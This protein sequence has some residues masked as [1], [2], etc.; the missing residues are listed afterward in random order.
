MIDYWSSHCWSPVQY[1]SEPWQEGKEK[2]VF[3][4]SS[5]CCRPSVKAAI[6]WNVGALTANLGAAPPAVMDRTTAAI[7]G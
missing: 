2:G 6:C 5:R 7:R 4:S 1:S 3:C